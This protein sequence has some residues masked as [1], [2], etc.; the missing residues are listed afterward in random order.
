[1]AGMISP[2]DWTIAPTLPAEV[3]R[4]FAEMRKHERK[5]TLKTGKLHSDMFVAPVLC[6]VVNISEG[7]ACILVPDGIEAPLDFRLEFDDGAQYDCR[8]CWRSQNRVGVM[9]IES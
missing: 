9:Y 6:A 8:V 3:H 1:M 7:G 4:T 2:V 5:L